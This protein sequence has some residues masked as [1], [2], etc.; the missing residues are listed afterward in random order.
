[1]SHTPT[2]TSMDT[3]RDTD[4]LKDMGLVTVVILVT[5]DTSWTNMELTK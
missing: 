3:Y 5:L 1:M 2:Y 4:M